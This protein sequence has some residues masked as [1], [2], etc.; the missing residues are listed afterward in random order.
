LSTAE[1]YPVVIVGAGPAGL[2]TS[3]ELRRR[4]I[5]HV[6]FERGTAPGHTW[7]QLYDSLTLHTGKHL[8][9]LPR[10]SFDRRIGIFPTR[11]DFVSYLHRYAEV[12]ELP[13][14]T[15]RAVTTVERDGDGWVVRTGGGDVRADAV[16]M[17]TGIV[18][19]PRAPDVAGRERFRGRVIHSVDYRRP[20]GYAGKRVLVVGVGNS[21]GEI[22]SELAAAGARVTVAVRSGA[23]V[24]PL[25]VAG[26]PIQYLAFA[27]RTLPVGVRRRIAAGVG[28]LTEMRRGPSPLPRPAHGP[29]DA[30]PLIGFHLVD[31]IKS[32]KVQVR[33]GIAE[34][35]ETGARFVDGIEEPFDEVIF[36][37]GFIAAIGPLGNLAR[38]DTKGFALRTDRVTSAD[39]PD[40]YFVGHTYD[41]T[42]GLHNIAQ[43]AVL[44]AERIASS[45]KRGVA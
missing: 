17:A 39:Q 38:T 20:A 21:G 18:A 19:A 22:A 27:M 7:M 4:N 13:V 25:R 28:K 1:R 23:N 30:I 24:V 10:M 32:G 33:R 2:A 29:L 8:S 3:A 31:A 42:G 35:T 40:L 12:F 26:I 45:R 5:E 34:L 15:G 11:N 14:E 16:V 6:V 9:S 36:A 43:D 41:A 44:A 37:T